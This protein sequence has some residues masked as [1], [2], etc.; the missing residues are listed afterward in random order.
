[1]LWF[2]LFPKR[3]IQSIALFFLTVELA[4]VRQE[5]VDL[6]AAEFPVRM[7]RMEC[8]HVEVNRTVGF[9]GESIV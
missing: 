5:L 8:P 2:S 9:V 1:M 4:R 3:E 7:H 6:T